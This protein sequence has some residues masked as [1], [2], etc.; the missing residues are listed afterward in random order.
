MVKKTKG[1]NEVDSAKERAGKST[2]M[3][4]SHLQPNKGKKQNQIMSQKKQKVNQ[5]STIS[6]TRPFQNSKLG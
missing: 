4:K 3:K 1:I 2:Q 6:I 5:I